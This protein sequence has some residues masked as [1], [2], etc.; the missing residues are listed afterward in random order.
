MNVSSPT[1]VCSRSPHTSRL[2]M[3]RGCSAILGSVILI[4]ALAACIGPVKPVPTQQSQEAPPPP[5]ETAEAPKA[6][7]PAPS[8]AP[9]SVATAPALPL[10]PIGIGRPIEPQGKEVC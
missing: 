10:P 5:T 7:E 6:A 9:P 3:N 8:D 4:I 2:I 1:P